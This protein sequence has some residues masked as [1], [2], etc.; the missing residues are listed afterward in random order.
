MVASESPA[1][2][3]ARF[4]ARAAICRVD[5]KRFAAGQLDRSRAWTSTGTLGVER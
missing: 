4:V 5:V 1:G 2:F 3:I